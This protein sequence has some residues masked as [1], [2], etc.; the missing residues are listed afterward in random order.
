MIL[1]C[2]KFGGIDNILISI[3]IY[4]YTN[5]YTWKI[6]NNIRRIAGPGRFGGVAGFTVAF[7]RLI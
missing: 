4:F 7:D 3:F 2:D 5:Y 1:Y 6:T